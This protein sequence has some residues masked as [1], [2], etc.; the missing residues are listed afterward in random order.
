MRILLDQG[1][2]HH[3][4]MGDAAMLQ[5]A[6]TRLRALWPNASIKVLTLAPDALATLCPSAEPVLADGRQQWFSRGIFADIGPRRL[7]A[8]VS[9]GR[10]MDRWVRQRYPSVAA[11]VIRERLRRRGTDDGSLDAFLGALHDADLV[12]V[13][14]G[15]LLTDAFAA[16]AASVLDTLAFAAMRGIPTA[17]LGHALGPV[18]DSAL[19]ARMRTVLPRV[20]LLTLRER[21]ASLPLLRSLGV[22]P[23]AVIVTG[24]DAVELA[25]ERGGGA[26]E[27]SAIGVNV[28]TASYANVSH[29]LVERIREPLRRVATA[30]RVPLVGVPISN[31]ASEAD[32]RAVH[33]LLVDSQPLQAGLPPVA[34]PSA[35]IE[36]VSVCRVVV[37]GSYHAAVFALSQGISAVGLSHSRYYTE[38]FLGLAEQFG[39]GCDI[40][41]LDQGAAGRQLERI[42]ADAWMSADDIRPRLLAAAQRQIDVGRSAYESLRQLVALRSAA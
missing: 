24:D 8:A 30:L 16:H 25:Y 7:P 9:V 15:G 26:G 14:G 18:S 32:E 4:N 33:A 13:A 31:V 10:S 36:R 17:M 12:A 5:V 40:V 27:G 38:K 34:S 1:S 21:R 19:L 28:R 2:Y 22:S 29:E 6:V 23:R 20:D 39:G 3:R 41:H 35:A 42:V 11:A 37:T